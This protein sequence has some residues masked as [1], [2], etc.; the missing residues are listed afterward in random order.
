[1]NKARRGQIETVKS[2]LEALSERIESIRDDE[3]D[4]FDNIPENLQD[5]E[6]ANM[7][8]AAIDALDSAIDSISEA[9]S[10]LEEAAE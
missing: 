3:Q 5:S 10:S 7:S 8:E 9:I 1:M 2:E 4:Y 6:R